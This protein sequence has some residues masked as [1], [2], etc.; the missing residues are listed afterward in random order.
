MHYH[1]LSSYDIMYYGR[2]F[3]MITCNYLLIGIWLC[4]AFL[5]GGE[6]AETAM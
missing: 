3:C 2:V 1:I 5:L 4:R 6:T